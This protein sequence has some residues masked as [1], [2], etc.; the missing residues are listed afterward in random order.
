MQTAHG[1]PLVLKGCAPSLGEHRDALKIPSPLGVKPIM[2]LPT[3][4][5]GLALS[6][7]PLLKLGL[8]STEKGVDHQINKP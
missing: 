8:A 6:D 4:K 3:A 1:Y 5:C 2:E 7:S